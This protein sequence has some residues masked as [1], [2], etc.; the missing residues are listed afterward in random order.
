MGS[1][2]G[3]RLDIRVSAAV[4]LAPDW[5]ACR[6]T[7]GADGKLAGRRLVLLK[8]GSCF[9]CGVVRVDELCRLPVSPWGSLNIEA[10][11]RAELSSFWAESQSRV[12]SL[13]C[14]DAA[15]TAWC[16]VFFLAFFLTTTFFLEHL[17]ETCLCA[18]ALCVRECAACRHVLSSRAG[19]SFPSVRPP[20]EGAPVRARRGGG[21]NIWENVS[22]RRCSTEN[23]VR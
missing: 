21:E 20:E 11:F 14:T 4:P 5:S 18:C 7:P 8:A 19:W 13:F 6:Q 12:H 3:S 2:T 16:F 17:G 22:A 9:A 10:T 1:K 23:I 15:D